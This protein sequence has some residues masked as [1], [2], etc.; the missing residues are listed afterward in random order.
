MFASSDSFTNL[1][2]GNS[3]TIID[4]IFSSI[5][6]PL[7]KN[8]ATGN[9]TFSISDHLPQFFFFLPDFFSNIPTREML[10]YMTGGDLIRTH[11]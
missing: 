4:N 6:E 10:T 11:F 3:K 7:I 8:V 9:I 5:A 1:D 2:C